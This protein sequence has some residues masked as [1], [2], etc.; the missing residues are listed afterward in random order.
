LLDFR[1]ECGSCVRV[2][3]IY[4]AVMPASNLV[5]SLCAGFAGLYF[6]DAP[7]ASPGQAGTLCDDAL[8]RYDAREL[9]GND[10][11]LITETD[12]VWTRLRIWVDLDADG[13]STSAEMR[14]LTSCG[15]R[16]LAAGSRSA[17]RGARVDVLRETAAGRR[18]R[19]N[20]FSR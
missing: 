14:T 20:P 13:V 11:G 12:A 18:P 9:G 7:P 17:G 19:A 8:A 2:V 16:A 10:D 1:D 15:I 3:A 5:L 6:A 4:R